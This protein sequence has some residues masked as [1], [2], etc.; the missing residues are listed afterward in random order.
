MVERLRASLPELPLA[1][2]DRLIAQYGLKSDAGALLSERPQDA[3]YFEATVKA[4]AEPR[5]AANWQTGPLQALCK[6]AKL[7]VEGAPISPGQLAALATAVASGSVGRGVARD[8][9]AEAFAAGRDP[10]DLV[11]ERGLSQVSDEDQLEKW[12]DAALELEPQAAADFK[13]G[14][15]KALGPLMAAVKRLS[16]GQ[17]NQGLANRILRDRLRPPAR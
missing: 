5:E 6:A 9:L 13:D 14:K 11:R 8:V 3:A 7:E 15:D 16:E 1:L 17:A 4:G 10:M 12:V 2:R